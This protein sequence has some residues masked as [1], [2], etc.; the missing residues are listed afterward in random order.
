MPIDEE[1]SPR[2]TRVTSEEFKAM[3]AEIRKQPRHVILSA[4]PITESKK[5]ITEICQWLTKK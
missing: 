3:I 5:D 1:A 4:T 2:I